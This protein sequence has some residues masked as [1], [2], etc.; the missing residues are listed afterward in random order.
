MSKSDRYNIY[1]A[2]YTVTDAEDN[3]VTV[4]E[5]RVELFVVPQGVPHQTVGARCGE[6]HFLSDNTYDYGYRYVDTLEDS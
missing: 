3:P 1:R 4:P 2:E 6:L 5:E